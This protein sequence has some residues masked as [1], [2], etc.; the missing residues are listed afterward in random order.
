MT[1]PMANTGKHNI[2]A[3]A[4]RTISAASVSSASGSHRVA[5]AGT[6]T[7]QFETQLT[8]LT[9]LQTT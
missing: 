4:W 3:K 9:G 2:L 8:E 7:K 6:L 1:V 5:A